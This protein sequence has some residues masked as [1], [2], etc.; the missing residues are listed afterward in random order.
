MKQLFIS[1][2]ALQI[3]EPYSNTIITVIAILTIFQLIRDIF[4]DRDKK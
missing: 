4:R 1:L 3:Q 2:T